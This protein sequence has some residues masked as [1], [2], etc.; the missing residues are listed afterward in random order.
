MEKYILSPHTDPE[1]ITCNLCET[2]DS[3]SGSIAHPRY[4]SNISLTNSYFHSGFD[5]FRISNPSRTKTNCLFH[6]QTQNIY[7]DTGT[8]PTHLNHASSP[9]RRCHPS[10]AI[11]LHELH[12]QLHRLKLWLLSHTKSPQD[13]EIYVVDRRRRC[14]ANERRGTRRSRL[15]S[16]VFNLP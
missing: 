5:M 13:G 16:D 12:S 2:W 6:V 1:I 3:L 11:I 14:S 15:S 8:R 7:R 10:D 4:V 9:I